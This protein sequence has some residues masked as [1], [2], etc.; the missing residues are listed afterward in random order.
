MRFDRLMM[1]AGVVMF[2]LAGCSEEPAATE[3]VNA[4]GGLSEVTDAPGA[5]DH[6]DHAHGDH[7]AHGDDAS[8]EVTEALGKLSEEDRAL[9]VSQ[10]FC[11]VSN[12]SLLGSMGAPIKLDVKGTPVF[13]CC[14]GC[15]TKALENPDE[16]L[17]TVAKMREANE[18]K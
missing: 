7:A 8:A 17:A 6:A 5:D 13:I 16:T 10:K 2:A 14:D 1:F 15:R 3:T 4:A 18:K 9:A 11:A 12:T